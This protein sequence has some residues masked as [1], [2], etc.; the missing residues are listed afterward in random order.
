MPTVKI[1]INDY[2]SSDGSST[3]GALILLGSDDNVN[4]SWTELIGGTLGTGD[5]GGS[6]QVI[7]SGGQVSEFQCLQTK[8][9]GHPY[10][11]LALGARAFPP[12][13]NDRGMGTHFATDSATFTDGTV[14]WA[15]VA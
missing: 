4:W 8:S 12:R 3:Q 7:Q 11:A 15:Y 14:T 13:Q 1:A 2:N 6:V 10:K 5:S 9:P